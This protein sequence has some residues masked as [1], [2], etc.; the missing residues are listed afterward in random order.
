MQKFNDI[1]QWIGAVT[2]IAGHVL[3]A[4]GPQA[5]PYNVITFFIG[6]VAFLIWSIRVHNRPQL[7][8]NT[9]ALVIG[10]VGIAKAIHQTFG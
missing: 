7:V 3:N 5:Y 9:V 8:V 1:V 6:T 2:I 10:F 4:L